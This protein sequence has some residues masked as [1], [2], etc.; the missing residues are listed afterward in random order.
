MERIQPHVP[1]DD[2]DGSRRVSRVDQHF[3]ETPVREIGIEGHGPL[4][5]RDRRFML[6]SATEGL[7][8]HGMR[9]GQIG[10]ELHGPAG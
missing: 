6:A 5:L 9:L 7:S 4:E 1:L 3:S 8:E 10:I 2:L